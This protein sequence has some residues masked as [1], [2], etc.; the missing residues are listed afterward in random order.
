MGIKGLWLASEPEISERVV[1]QAD[2]AL[3]EIPSYC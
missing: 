1:V 2:K 3:K